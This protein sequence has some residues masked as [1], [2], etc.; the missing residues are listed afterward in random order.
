M[1]SAEHLVHTADSTYGFLHLKKMI[2]KMLVTW[3]LPNS[4]SHSVPLFGGSPSLA[5]AA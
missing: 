4:K 5:P 3:P 1:D 2:S